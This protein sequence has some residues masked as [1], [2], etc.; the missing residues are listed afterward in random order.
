VNPEDIGTVIA[1]L[2][3]SE[4]RWITGQDVEVSGGYNL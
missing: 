1:F 4:A 3:S 2:L